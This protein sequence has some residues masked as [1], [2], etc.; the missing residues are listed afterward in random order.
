MFPIWREHGRTSIWVDIVTLWLSEAWKLEKIALAGTFLRQCGYMQMISRH[1]SVVKD[2][3]LTT[4]QVDRW[5]LHF[6]DYDIQDMDVAPYFGTCVQQYMEW[7]WSVSHPYVINMAKDD[8]PV[9]I[10]LKAPIHKPIAT[11]P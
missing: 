1:S 3:D 5:W 7:F 11:H 9:L 4:N 8:C 10:P 6:N 2:G